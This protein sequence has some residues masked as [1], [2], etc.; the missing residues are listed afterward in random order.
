MMEI[1]EENLHGW[2]GRLDPMLEDWDQWFTYFKLKV[3]FYNQLLLSVPGRVSFQYFCKLLTH[4]RNLYY[5]TL[6][7]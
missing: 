3:I 5:S 2:S 1:S 6:H 4:T 7:E